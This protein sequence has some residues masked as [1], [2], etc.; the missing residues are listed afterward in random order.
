MLILILA[1]AKKR[2]CKP[3][4]KVA[5]AVLVPRAMA[6]VALSRSNLAEAMDGVGPRLRKSTGAADLALIRNR[7]LT[8]ADGR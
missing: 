6:V 1:V 5:G 4:P 3:G 7:I 8:R 2:G